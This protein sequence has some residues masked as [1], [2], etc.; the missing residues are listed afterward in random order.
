LEIV[1]TYFPPITLTEKK[2][3]AQKLIEQLDSVP[4]GRMYQASFKAVVRLHLYFTGRTH[5]LVLDFSEKAQALVLKKAGKDQVLDGTSG[6]VVQTDLLKMWGDLFK[7]W[8][9][10]LQAVRR[11][12][13]S[14][15]FGVLAVM[16]ERM[17]I[18]NVSNRE[19]RQAREGNPLEEAGPVGGCSN[20]RCRPY[21]M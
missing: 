17:V 18:P 21:W 9:D 15:P 1:S 2:S 5:E 19:E 3:K 12:A 20:G 13:V 4:L 10:E 14:I 16:H 7:V 8:Q 6:F 11:E